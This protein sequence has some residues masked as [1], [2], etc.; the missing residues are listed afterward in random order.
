M[1][2]SIAEAASLLGVSPATLRRLESNEEVKGYGI[3]VYYTP[4][5]QRRYLR[6]EIEQFY[7]D[8][9]FAGRVGFGEKPAL[10]VID[11]INGF[12]R[13]SSPL[14]ANWDA[15]VASI[16][17]L[18]VAA[19]HWRIPV[20]F[21]HSYYAAEEEGMQLWAKK[22]RGIETLLLDSDETELDPRIKARK[23]DHHINSKYTSVYY[24][25]ELLDL[26]RAHDVD[27]L[28]IS[29]FST[30]GSVRSVAAESTQYGIRPI[31]PM[32]A[33]GDRDGHMHRTN[34]RDIDKKF[35]DVLPV[36]EVIEHMATA[37]GADRNH[38][39]G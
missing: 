15:E 32:E 13:T 21:S 1:F 34:L 9:G 24:D 26:L 16:N 5:G 25:T 12:T 37:R 39:K 27:T 11:C 14:G 23:G 18:I 28:V 6:A 3:R 33:V 17:K 31:V 35:A 4:G 29:G 8:R 36:S 7:L 19:H 38:E 22:I 20:V 10:L 30:S 2:V